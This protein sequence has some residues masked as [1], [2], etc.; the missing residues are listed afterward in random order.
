MVLLDYNAMIPNNTI[1]K[2]GYI[3]LLRVHFD[4]L[5]LSCFFRYNILYT[6]ITDPPL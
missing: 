1:V 6:T 5:L 3:I 2:I 4:A